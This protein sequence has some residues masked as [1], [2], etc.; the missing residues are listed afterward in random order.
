MAVE[1]EPLG[2]RAGGGHSA[3]TQT[4]RSLRAVFVDPSLRRIQLALAASL[5]GDWAYST[6]VTVWAYRA[7]GAELVGLQGSIV[8]GGLAVLG[9]TAAVAAGA[10]RFR[11]YDA[12]QPDEQVRLASRPS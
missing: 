11:A 9:I 12:R 7:G 8:G 6:A 5:V 10:T 2:R 4:W 3:L 1:A